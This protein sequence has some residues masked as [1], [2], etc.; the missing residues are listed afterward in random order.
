MDRRKGAPFPDNSIIPKLVS[1]TKEG[2][3]LDIIEFPQLVQLA[4]TGCHPKISEWIFLPFVNYKTNRFP[5]FL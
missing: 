2:G 5:D 1:E 3:G 4:N